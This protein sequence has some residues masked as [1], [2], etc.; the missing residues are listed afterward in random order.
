MVSNAINKKE[1]R[2]KSYLFFVSLPSFLKAFSKVPEDFTKP[3]GR[4]FHFIETIFQNLGSFQEIIGNATMQTAIQKIRQ[5]LQL[6]HKRPCW[7]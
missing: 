1:V 7:G 5:P 4:F 3:S 2:P 6:C